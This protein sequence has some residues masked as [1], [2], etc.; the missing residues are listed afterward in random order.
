MQKGTGK[1]YFGCLDAL[2]VRHCCLEHAML[3][4]LCHLGLLLFQALLCSGLDRR[5]GH[6]VARA[7]G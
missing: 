3:L 2:R 5:G 7:S 4:A 1:A 6:A